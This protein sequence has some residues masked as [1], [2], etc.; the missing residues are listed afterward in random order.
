MRPGSGG[1]KADTVMGLRHTVM[2]LLRRLDDREPRPGDRERRAGAVKHG[3][4]G[5]L[6][7]DHGE[8]IWITIA[9]TGY[10]THPHHEAVQC[11][12]PME[13]SF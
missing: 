8:E 6:G 9:N 7:G 13:I 11:G 1:D 3:P 5:R 2:G 12:S 4:G 10:V